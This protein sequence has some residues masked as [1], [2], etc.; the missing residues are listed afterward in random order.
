MSDVRQL[1]KLARKP[2]GPWEVRRHARMGP[3]NGEVWR[4]ECYV[5]NRYSVQVSDVETDWGPV[6][7]LW[8][9]RHAPGMPRSWRDL[10]R[11]KDTIVGEDRVAVEVFPAAGDIIDQAD[12]AHLWVLPA[13][14]P[15]PFALHRKGS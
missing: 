5:N 8:V 14:R 13:D 10:Q 2:F 9:R 15:L 1:K 4:A 12:M 7:H 3:G 6:V 11:I